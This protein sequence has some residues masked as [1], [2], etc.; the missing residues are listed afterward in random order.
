MNFKKTWFGYLNFILASIFISAC[1]IVLVFSNL[2]YEMKDFLENPSSDIISS[3]LNI[4]FGVALLLGAL[5]LCFA[6]AIY[7]LIRKLR[8]YLCRKKGFFDTDITS[9]RFGGIMSLLIFCAGLFLRIKAITDKDVFSVNVKSTINSLNIQSLFDNERGLVFSSFNDFYDSIVAIVY[10]F[11]GIKENVYMWVNFALHIVL[12]ILIYLVV[13]HLYNACV[14]IVPMLFICLYPENI[15]LVVS[16]GY[17]NIEI[18]LVSLVFLLTILLIS[19]LAHTKYYRI[20]SLVFTFIA[21]VVCLIGL[22]MFIK[23]ELTLLPGFKFEINERLYDFALFERWDWFCLG[24][25]VLLLY[26][27][28]SFFFTD[29]DKLSTVFPLWVSVM[30]FYIFSDSAWAT[31]YYA[32]V[33]T[34]VFGGVGFDELF[35]SKILIPEEKEIV[36]TVNHQ[37]S[38]IKVEKPETKEIVPASDSNNPNEESLLTI[39]PVNLTVE[40]AVSEE[41]SDIME[42]T[43]KEAVVSDDVVTDNSDNK[44]EQLSEET[45]EK[46]KVELFESPLPLPK[47]HKKKEIAFKFEPSSDRMNFDVDITDDDDFDV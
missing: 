47:K 27:S 9:E 7:V 5:F 15:K 28:I 40:N 25:F 32:A 11:T 31:A 29:R 21:E 13:M 43:E 34:A 33:V 17:E 2:Q 3:H 22:P 24:I 14:A 46:P 16:G 44:S 38:E 8:E 6:T 36:K 26:A 4:P 1:V 42:A 18:I 30:I 23:N 19:L 20:I 10:R 12:I 37:A 35:T 41:Q 45:E 39:T